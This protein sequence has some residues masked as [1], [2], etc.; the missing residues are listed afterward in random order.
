M[1]IKFNFD[2]KNES[3]SYLKKLRILFFLTEN[4]KSIK[5]RVKI[6]TTVFTVIVRQNEEANFAKSK[7]KSKSPTPWRPLLLL[8]S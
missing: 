1:T 5:E 8:L 3:V 7:I 6:L 4:K 2:D